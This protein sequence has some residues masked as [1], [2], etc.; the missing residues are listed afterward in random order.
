[1]HMKH[2]TKKCQ[3]FLVVTDS[4]NQTFEHLLADESSQLIGSGASAAIQLVDPDVASVHCVVR[5]SQGAL[6]IDDWC[7]ATGT[8]VNGVPIEGETPLVDCDTVQLGSHKIVIRFAEHEEFD[9]TDSGDEPEPHRCDSAPSFEVDEAADEVEYESFEEHCDIGQEDMAESQLP[10]SSWAGWF[11]DADESS[12]VN[13]SVEPLSV[14]EETIKL[15]TH[16]I[17]ALQAELGTSTSYIAEL[18]EKLEA[19]QSEGVTP[20]DISH[21]EGRLQELLGELERSDQRASTFEDL[22]QISDHA[23][24]AEKEERQQI[25]TWVSDIEQRITGRED[26]WHGE[27][28][29]L[30]KQIEQL[31][32]DNSRLEET[33]ASSETN[34]NIELQERAIHKLRTELAE[35]EDRLSKSESERRELQE[36]VDSEDMETMLERQQQIVEEAIREEQLSIARE[37]AAFSRQKSELIRRVSDLESELC[38][39]KRETNEAD[40]RFNAFRQHLKEI[41]EPESRPRSVPLTKRLVN[42]WNRLEYGPTDTE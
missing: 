15:L 18:E 12:D 21:L 4:N 26:E 20:S 17:S 14:D 29:L 2:A 38:G 42:L 28:D 33:L 9:S 27:K 23:T 3:V 37:R 34:T 11:G 39:Q 5:L 6:A 32:S 36:K 25:E 41:Q 24:Q 40:V 13:E 22:L 19:R 30:L 16:E 1:M 10:E 31:Q 35:V 8:I 7:S